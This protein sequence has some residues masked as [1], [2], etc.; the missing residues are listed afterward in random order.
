M[1]PERATEG[2]RGELDL[3]PLGIHTQ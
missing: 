3:N 1:S 2:E